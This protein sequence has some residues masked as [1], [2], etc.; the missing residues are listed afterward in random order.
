MALQPATP[1]PMH[2]EQVLRHLR[3]AGTQPKNQNAL[4]GAAPEELEMDVPHRV[5]TLGLDQVVAGADLDTAV[6]SGWRYLLKQGDQVV[7][8]AQTVTDAGGQA[9]FA[10]FNSGPYVE[11]TSKALST[12]EQYA[13][14]GEGSDDDW[15]PRVLHVPALHAMALWLHT[16]AET[17]DVV[18]PLPPVAAG[19]EPNRR[20]TVPD[21]LAALRQLAGSVQAAS[22][23]E[24]T[25]G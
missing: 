25:G 23:G 9:A 21:Y 22:A 6:P 5:Y 19:I 11:S 16:D 3:R 1:S 24:T 15:E 14:A 20:Y 2:D 12:A 4:A 17:T 18:L 8:A 7:A 10:S 13:G